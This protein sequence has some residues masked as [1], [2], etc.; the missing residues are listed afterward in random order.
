M[1]RLEARRVIVTGGGESAVTGW[2]PL[3]SNESEMREL[4]DE[5]NTY[6]LAPLVVREAPLFFGGLDEYDETSD[7]RDQIKVLTFLVVCLWCW[8]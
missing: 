5:E 1:P 8:Q 4:S 3:Q 6:F 2:T 7:E